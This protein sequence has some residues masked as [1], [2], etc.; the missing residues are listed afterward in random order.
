[1]ALTIYDMH[2]HTD[3]S[4]D[5]RQPIDELCA[6]EIAAG[7]TG[8]AVTD[9]SDGPYSHQNGDFAR[10]EQSIR[11]CAAAAQRYAGRLEV[12]C[13]VEI[14]EE[15]WSGENARIVHEL[16]E[17]DV[18]LTSIH[19]QMEDGRCVYL[20][21]RD[22][23][24]WS[25]ARLEAYLQRYLYDLA[26]CAQLADYDILTHLDIPLRYINGK[27]GHAL[28][29]EKFADLV[30]EVLRI[31]I[32]RDKTLEINTSGMAAGWRC[33]PQTDVL[34][35]YYALGGRRVSVGSDAHA[36]A[37]AAVGFVSVVEQ[38]RAVGFTGQ[39]IYRRRQPVEIP[40]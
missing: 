17:Y 1:M 39:T 25:T 26:E 15:L 8:V 40:F 22:L 3:C 27:A 33:M 9:H 13:G 16:G 18:I 14:G 36:S 31:V 29:L 35:R 28:Q 37:A 11:N 32:Q 19:G 6:A 20:G 10:L 38:L 34:R 5:S 21:D 24:G 30:D 23:P 7:M 12:L 4:H 2:T